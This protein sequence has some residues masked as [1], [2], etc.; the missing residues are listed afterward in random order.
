MD[1][2]GAE[3]KSERRIGPADREETFWLKLAD[4]AMIYLHWDSKVERQNLI[5]WA[6]VQL[7]E[8]TWKKSVRGHCLLQSIFSS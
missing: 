3:P 4:Y 7:V 6:G 5:Q 1:C 2:L 8:L